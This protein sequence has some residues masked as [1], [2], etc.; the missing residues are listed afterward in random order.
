MVI[1]EKSLCEERSV[2][3]PIQGFRGCASV[4]GTREV[5]GGRVLCAAGVPD[6]L[7]VID[8]STTECR[9]VRNLCFP[10]IP[11]LSVCDQWARVAARNGPC[12]PE[13][14]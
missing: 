6:V 7:A 4:T 9:Q 5:M 3:R 10:V 8:L 12:S 14:P 1:G 11:Q 13:I 2:L